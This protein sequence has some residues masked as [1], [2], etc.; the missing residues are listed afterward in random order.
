MNRTLMRW[1]CR[2]ALWLS[3]S[4]WYTDLAGLLADRVTSAH[5]GR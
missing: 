3:F 2:L 4:F 5:R 1:A